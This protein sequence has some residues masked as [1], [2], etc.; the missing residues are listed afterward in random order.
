MDRDAEPQ[1]LASS[2]PHA[3]GSSDRGWDES[4]GK[5]IEW[6]PPAFALG[7]CWTEDGRLLAGVAVNDA[8]QI[9][10]VF[11]RNK[12]RLIAIRSAALHGQT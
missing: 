2:R 7:S 6:M 4:G 12:V 11:P 5:I 10:R 1:S 3:R 8:L 9:W